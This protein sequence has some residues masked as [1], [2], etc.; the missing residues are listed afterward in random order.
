MGHSVEMARLAVAAGTDTMAATPHRA[1]GGRREAPPDWVRD[2]VRVLQTILDTEGVPLRVV[3]GV[4]I[5]LAPSVAAELVSGKL[6]TLGDAGSWA[7]IEPPFDHLPRD[8]VDSVRAVRNAGF[9]V[10]IAHPE[11]CGEIQRDLSFVEACA[12]LGC[13]FQLTTGSLLGFF[14][15]RVQQTAEII[16]T[17]AAE[18]PLVLASDAHDLRERN[19]G[20][21]TLAVNRAAEIVG[22]ALALEMADTRPRSFVSPA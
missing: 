12:E 5:P 22:E 7:L 1:Y 14:G 4:E 15:G 8:G 17:R 19:P 13:A 9:G 20:L 16:L 21:M 10:V 3:P 2:Q 18:W 6:L 11:R